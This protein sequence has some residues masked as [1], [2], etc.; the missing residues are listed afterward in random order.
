MEALLAKNIAIHGSSRLPGLN[1]SSGSNVSSELNINSRLTVIA[2]V[3]FATTAPMSEC[4]SATFVGTIPSSITT[5]ADSRPARR[6][7]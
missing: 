5:V 7:S 1:I 3:V 6:R 4:T 2:R